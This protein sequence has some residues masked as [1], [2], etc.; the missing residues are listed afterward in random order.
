M[1]VP[2]MA[3]KVVQLVSVWK[4]ITIPGERARNAVRKS[5]ILSMLEKTADSALGERPVLASE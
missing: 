5:L 3:S 1:D 2:A 4:L